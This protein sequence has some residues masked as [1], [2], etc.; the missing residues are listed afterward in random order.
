MSL[1][2]NLGGLSL[3]LGGSGGGSQGEYH[4]NYRGDYDNGISYNTDDV[5]FYNGGCGTALPRRISRQDT[6]PIAARNAGFKSP[7]QEVATRSTR[8]SM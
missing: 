2:L 4:W 1:L 5:V 8:A 3:D 6:R 7:A